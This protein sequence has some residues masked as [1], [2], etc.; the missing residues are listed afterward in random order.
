MDGRLQPQFLDS[1]DI[2]GVRLVR[3]EVHKSH[4][5]ARGSESQDAEE[6]GPFLHERG[7]IGRHRGGRDGA[8]DAQFRRQ[9]RDARIPGLGTDKT[10]RSRGALPGR[11]HQALSFK[12]R[13]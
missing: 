8:A 9:A 10:N 7:R 12:N 2:A 5:E 11:S 3:A 13:R 4:Q 1:A 6:F